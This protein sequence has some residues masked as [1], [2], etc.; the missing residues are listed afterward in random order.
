M[1][2][3]IQRQVAVVTNAA[4]GIGKAVAKVLLENGATVFIAD[5]SDGDGER[6]AREL[7]A[8]GT[9]RYVHAD[10]TRANEVDSLVNIVRDEC[11]RIDIMVNNAGINAGVDGVT[12]DHIADKDWDRLIAVNLGGAFYC[13]RAISRVMIE[14]RAGRI[15]NIGS[16]LG[17]IPA[18]KQI[19]F[20]AANAGSQNMT[21]ALALELGTF[22]ICV[23]GVAVGPIAVDGSQGDD[24]TSPMAQMLSHVPLSRFGTV[25]EVANAI[26]FLCGKESGYITG[27][28]M[29][30]DGGWTCGYH[31]DF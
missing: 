30:V 8:L 15:I 31:R 7:S 12:V 13:C 10:V 23:N 18:R 1:K 19:A 22:G 27:H 26:L 25:E 9:C 29:T 5:V 17:S 6:T 16:V 14:Q 20:M 11:G 24:K 21:K 4:K 3:D 28:I 2:V